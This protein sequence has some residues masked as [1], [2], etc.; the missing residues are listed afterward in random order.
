MPGKLAYIGQAAV[1]TAAAPLAPQTD[2]VAT[3][4][5]T[6][7]DV[8]GNPMVADHTWVFSTAAG[9]DSTP[10]RVVAV[11]P[12]P[13]ATGVPRNAALSVS[14][15]EPIYP[16]VYGKLDDA[17]VTVSIDYATQTVTMAPGTP[18]KAGG[19]Y[20]ASV[21]VMDLAGNVMAEPYRWSFGAAP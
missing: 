17:V 16:F 20:Q 10:P 11:T 4:R 9:A 7:S 13:G 21:S 8:A 5:R 1:F 19:G 15:D 6:A 14:F 3:L 18:L 12:A 2:Y